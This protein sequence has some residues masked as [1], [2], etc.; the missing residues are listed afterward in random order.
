MLQYYTTLGLVW[1]CVFIHKVI[2]L[3]ILIFFF[4]FKNRLV[5]ID[6]LAFGYNNEPIKANSLL[7]AFSNLLTGRFVV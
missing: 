5:N 7:I 1:D 4:Q 2:K 3:L 6:I